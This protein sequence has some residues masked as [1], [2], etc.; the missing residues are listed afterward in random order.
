MQISISITI[1][2][3]FAPRRIT[4]FVNNSWIDS[5]SESA[6]NNCACCCRDKLRRQF[7][8]A[9]GADAAFEIREEKCCDQKAYVPLEAKEEAATENWHRE[10][11]IFSAKDKLHKWRNQ[12]QTRTSCGCFSHDT[13]NPFRFRIYSLMLLL[14]L[15]ILTTQ[16]ANKRKKL[17]N[18]FL[19]AL[20]IV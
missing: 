1:C 17:K 11:K 13:I 15:H 4:E 19:P 8:C 14:P 3:G 20:L 6:D 16:R 10:R 2:I 12:R 5:I 7:S 18:L 9:C